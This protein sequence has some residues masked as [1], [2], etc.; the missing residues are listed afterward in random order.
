MT[1]FTSR[2]TIDGTGVSHGNQNEVQTLADPKR[3]KNENI[4]MEHKWHP[5]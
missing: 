2:L 3:L 1:K 5:I 4:N